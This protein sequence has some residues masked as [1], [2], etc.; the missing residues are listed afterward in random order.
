MTEKER[1][2]MRNKSFEQGVAALLVLPPEHAP[3]GC[4]H[5]KHIPNHC[6]YN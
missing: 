1:E 4:G 5:H 2:F 6:T 3:Q